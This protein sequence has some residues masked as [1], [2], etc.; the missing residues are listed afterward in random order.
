MREASS[1]KITKHKSSQ[2]VSMGQCIYCG[3]DAGLLRKFHKDCKSRYEA[4]QKKLTELA[5]SA[6]KGSADLTTTRTAVDSIVA[7][8]F[9]R[10]EELKTT[11]VNGFEVSVHQALEDGIITQDEEDA[12]DK[13]KDYFRLTQNDLDTS[14]AFTKLVQAGVLRDL[15]DGKIPKRI[16]ITGQIPFNLQKSEELVWVFQDVKYYEVRSRTS[17][18]GGYSGMSV[19]VAKGLYYRTGSF[20]GNPIVTSEATHAGTGILGITTKHIYFAGGQKAF[21]VPYQKIVSFTPYS[22]GF[23]LQRDAQTA[24]PQSFVVGDGWF[25]YNLVVNL[26]KLL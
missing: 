18:S 2:G 15:M 4:G 19:R 16:N 14:G 8:S 1:G 12:L 22:D 6:A 20:R 3:N 23:G 17:Y 11:L 13:Y 21:R 25:V 7:G 26:S 24:K 10:P 9:I 5:L